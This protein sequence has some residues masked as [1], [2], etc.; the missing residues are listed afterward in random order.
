MSLDTITQEINQCGVAET[1]H[2]AALGSGAGQTA[3]QGFADGGSQ[4]PDHLALTM[5]FFNLLVRSSWLTVR[6]SA[7]PSS[8]VLLQ[9]QVNGLFTHNSALLASEAWGV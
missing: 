3:P 6:L 7:G 1:H 8:L 2:T 5:E 9:G 4:R